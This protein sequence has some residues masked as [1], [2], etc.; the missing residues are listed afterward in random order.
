MNQN[1]SETV[2]NHY[3]NPRNTG[4]LSHYTH[5]AEQLN[6]LCG[7][8]IKVYVEIKDNKIKD[9]SHESRG[10]M[11]SIAAA[12]VLSEFIKGKS[13]SAIK[14]ITK[15]DIDKLLGVTVSKAR[16]PCATLA[17]IAIQKLWVSFSPMRRGR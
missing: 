4:R 3:H 17:L 9:L 12:S 14:K 1:Y 2:K 5:F 7:D 11:I 10:C 6:P 8:E 15:K 16:E 13:L